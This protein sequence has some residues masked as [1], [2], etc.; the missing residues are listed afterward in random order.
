M[1]LGWLIAVTLGVVVWCV[2]VARAVEVIGGPWE[3]GPVGNDLIPLPSPVWM[4]GLLLGVV[5][6]MCS[7]RR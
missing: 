3:Q 7:R 4:G 5:V 6:V 2:G 1:R